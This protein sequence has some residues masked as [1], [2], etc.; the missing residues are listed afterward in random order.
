MLEIMN[1]SREDKGCYIKVSQIKPSS[2]LAWINKVV[3]CL[4]D[5]SCMDTIVIRVFYFIAISH[6]FNKTLELCLLEILEE[7]IH[8]EDMSGYK[9]KD[10]FLSKFLLHLNNVKIVLIQFREDIKILRIIENLNFSHVFHQLL[11]FLYWS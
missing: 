11:Q 1:D 2:D 3:S 5:I 10:Y 7:M 8:A 4:C 6:F 9:G